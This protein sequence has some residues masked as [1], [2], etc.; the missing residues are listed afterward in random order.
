M[1]TNIKSI[2]FSNNYISNN[3]QVH[4]K[5]CCTPKPNLNSCDSVSF[6]GKAQNLSKLSKE[7]TELVQN[8]A[9]KLQ[10]NKIYK[11]STP[12]VEKFNLVSIANKE[13]PAMR[14]L[15]VQYSDFRNDDTSQHIMFIVNNNGE[16]LENG[17]KVRNPRQVELYEKILPELINRASKDL[18]IKM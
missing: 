17:T 6:S 3:N 2:N 5:R 7:S 1:I 12:D 11:F 10:L 13:N 16:I 15:V 8:F 14:N 9:Q 4:S 18:K